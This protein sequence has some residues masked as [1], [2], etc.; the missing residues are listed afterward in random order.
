MWILFPSGAQGLM[1]NGNCRQSVVCASPSKYDLRKCP[2]K[3]DPIDSHGSSP[4]KA[5][6][7]L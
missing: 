3:I 7:I 4:V 6:M 2:D 1:G 5:S